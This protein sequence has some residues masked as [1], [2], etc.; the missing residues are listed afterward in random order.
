MGETGKIPSSEPGED[1]AENRR[2]LR[3]E[4]SGAK[5]GKGRKTV[6]T[7]HRI[8]AAVS[9]GKPRSVSGFSTDLKEAREQQA[10]AGQILKSSR[11]RVLMCSLC[12]RSSPRDRNGWLMRCRSL[13]LP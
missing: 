7:K 4:G 5:S 6:K 2:Q 8:A 9:R 10:A 13:S 12:S 1:D 11:V 3:E